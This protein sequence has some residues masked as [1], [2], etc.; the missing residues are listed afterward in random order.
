MFICIFILVYSRGILRHFEPIF[1]MRLTQFF[2]LRKYIRILED[3]SS[4][5]HIFSALK[6]RFS[7]STSCLHTFTICIIITYLYLLIKKQIFFIL[8]VFHSTC[9]SDLLW[10]HPTCSCCICNKPG[11]A[12]REQFCQAN[13][14]MWMSMWIFSRGNSLQAVCLSVCSCERIPFLWNLSALSITK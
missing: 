10:S 13:F 6:V 11:S 2:R 4:T 14:S 12:L 3:F 5:A 1:D 8:F 9:F 7:F